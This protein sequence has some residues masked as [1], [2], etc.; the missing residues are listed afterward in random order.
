M[1]ALSSNSSPDFNARDSRAISTTINTVPVSELVHGKKGGNWAAT[2]H[3]VPLASLRASTSTGALSNETEHE[4]RPLAWLLLSECISPNKDSWKAECKVIDDEYWS[5][6]SE[7]LDSEPWWNETSW[8]EAGCF[9]GCRFASTRGESPVPDPEISSSKS[10]D[11]K[12]M[13]PYQIIRAPPTPS[14]FLLCEIIKDVLRTHPDLSFYISPPHSPHRLLTLTRVLYVWSRLNGG[15]KYVQGMNE[16]IGVVFFVMGHG[17]KW[18]KDLGGVDTEADDARTV[19][20]VESLTYKVTTWL[21]NSM[22]D[23][24]TPSLDDDSTGVSGRIS[25]ITDKVQMHDPILANHLNDLGCEGTFYLMRWITTLLSREFTMPDTVRIWDGMFGSNQRDNYVTYVCVTMVV[26]VREEL[27][28]GDFTKCIE[29]LQNYPPD[30]DVDELVRRARAL[31]RFEVMVR[32]VCGGMRCNIREGMQ[33]VGPIEGVIMAFGWRGGIVEGDVGEALKHV[34]DVIKVGMGE[35]GKDAGA[36]AKKMGGN[37]WGWGQ[38]AVQRANAGV[39]RAA[40]IRKEK[41]RERMARVTMDKMRDDKERQTK[42]QAKNKQFLAQQEEFLTAQLAE[43]GAV[44]VTSGAA[45]GKG[46]GTTKEGGSQ[47]QGSNTS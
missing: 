44:E 14:S 29:I 22:V 1:S 36:M 19:K 6:V 46:G 35:I 31:F 30:I 9:D 27:L 16:V 37:L 38:A 28:V 11:P 18:F 40:E 4:L 21:L 2:S 33:H 17:E 26:M 3:R 10:S 25:A 45:K 13:T 42:E 41:D 43:L 5:F 12:K 20:L 23:I 34:K 7:L 8:I 24:F 32:E 47:G 15:V 39:E